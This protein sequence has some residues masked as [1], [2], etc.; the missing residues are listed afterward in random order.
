MRQKKTKL[1]HHEQPG[2]SPGTLTVPEGAPFPRIHLFAYDNNNIAEHEIAKVEDIKP[3]LAKWPVTWVNVEGLGSVDIIR[4]LGDLFTL[5]PL[6]LED[7]VNI[8][9]RP[10]TD[11]YDSN[12]FVILKMMLIRDGKL[13]IEQ[14]SMFLGKNYVL[15]FL[16]DPGDVLNPVRDRLR[17]GLGRK[18]RGAG[19]D[20]LAYALLDAIID[21][22]FPVLEFYGDQL[23]ELEDAVIANS[24]PEIIARTHD[25][26]RDLRGLRHVMWPLRDV[27]S[28]LSDDNTM[29]RDDIHPYMRDCHDHVIQVLDLLEIYRE[30][31]AGLVDIYLSSLSYRMN[32]IMKV[33]TIIATIFIPLTFI[34]GVYGMNFDPDA[35]P[36]NM[37][38]LRWEYGYPFSIA[39]M[40][41]VTGGLL[42]YFRH[43][44]W[45]GGRKR[46]PKDAP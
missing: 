31:A 43:R 24:T 44:G 45:L 11:E 13:C 15:T 19:P 7:V 2:A 46:K 35:S 41:A 3:F 36:W 33:L 9:H 22:Y 38:E 10:K 37:P 25:I 17:R 1:R 28:L 12:L 42:G 29:I 30:R 39:V 34:V 4:Q 32:E 21:G 5:H 8:N 27:I 16:E 20:Y 23:N 26:K 14:L 6:A 40:L 18:I